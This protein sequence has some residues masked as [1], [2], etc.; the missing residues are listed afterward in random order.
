V[1]SGI[2]Y[3]SET[4]AVCPYL[5]KCSQVVTFRS[6]NSAGAAYATTGSTL[7]IADQLHELLHSADDVHG[8][9]HI[10]GRHPAM[11]LALFP[12]NSPDE[13][14]IFVAQAQNVQQRLQMRRT[15]RS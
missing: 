8:R 12:N 10:L 15:R 14:V 3:H 5:V 4:R 11:L 2:L 6:L 1:L 7:S 13:A 9:L